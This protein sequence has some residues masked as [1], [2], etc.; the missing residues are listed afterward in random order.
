MPISTRTALALCGAAILAGAAAPAPAASVNTQGAAILEGEAFY[1]ARGGESVSC[2]N[3]VVTLVPL[4]TAGGAAIQPRTTTCDA[5]GHFRFANLPA[6][7]WTIRVSIRWQAP[8]KQGMRSFG[9]DL[10]QA[11]TLQPGVNTASLAN[12]DLS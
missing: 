7:T 3:R 11:V 8:A 2:A 1:T 4:A 5:S 12:H 10:E 6:A 9:G